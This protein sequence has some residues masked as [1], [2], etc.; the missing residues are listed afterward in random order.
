MGAGW[1]QEYNYEAEVDGLVTV[2]NKTDGTD[3]HQIRVPPMMITHTLGAYED[4]ETNELHFDVLH[5]DNALAYTYYTFIDKV[6][7]GKPHPNNM[8]KIMRYTLDMGDWTLKDG[9][10]KDLI[11]DTELNHSFEFSNINPR[12]LGKKYRFGYFSENVFKTDGAVVKV[13]VDTGETIQKKLPNGLFPTEPIFV[14]RPGAEDEDD[15][16]IVMSGIDGAQEKGYVIIYDAKDMEEIFRATAPRKTLF[17][18][19]SKFFS[20]TDGCWQPS[21]DCTPTPDPTSNPTTDPTATTSDDGSCPEGW[22]DAG[23][24]GC[25][26]VS[27]ELTVSSWYEANLLCEDLGGYLVEPMS[28]QIHAFLSTMLVM[29]PEV[30]GDLDW[31]IGLTDTGHEGTWAWQHQ[32]TVAEDQFWAEGYPDKTPGNDADCALMAREEGF[33][34]RDANCWEA[35]T[36]SRGLICQH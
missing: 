1:E 32:V 28:E 27:T 4:P 16:V 7:D 6:L 21:G 17:G 12:Y 36:Q 5:Y 29:L 25:F 10:P 13:N 30:A 14:G 11:P 24:L 9:S 3:F 35:K 26:Y 19:H 2:M 18:V 23:E 33:L 34:W 8:T 22:M 31:W 20:F 15:G